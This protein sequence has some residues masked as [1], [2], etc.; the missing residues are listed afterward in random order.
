[1]IDRRLLTHFDWPLLTLVFII[2]SI[3]VLNLYSATFGEA[4]SNLY[5]R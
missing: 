4:E 3:G 1:M 2:S 5:A